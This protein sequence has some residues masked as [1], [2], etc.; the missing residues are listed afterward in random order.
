MNN[1]NRV[2]RTH[3]SPVQ[4]R[5]MISKKPP[6][7]FIS[8]GK[9]YRKDDDA[10]HLPMFHQIEGLY[11]DEDVSFSILKDLIFKIIHQLFDETIKIRFRPIFS[12]Y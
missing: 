2:L 12:I 3:T 7:A 9:V 8:G 4:I 6:I 11:V 10:T 1:G 5:G